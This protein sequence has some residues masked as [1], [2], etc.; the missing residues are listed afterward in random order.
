MTP[1]DLNFDKDRIWRRTLY[2]WVLDLYESFI[3]RSVL[4]VTSFKKKKKRFCIC[5]VH[6][7]RPVGRY[8]ELKYEFHEWHAS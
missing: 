7:Q 1:V 4:D 6:V 3:Y 8:S 2:F 5:V